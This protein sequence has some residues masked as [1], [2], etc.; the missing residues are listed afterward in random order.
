M[1]RYSRSSGKG[2]A[3]VLGI[4]F[5]LAIG[6]CSGLVAHSTKE[7]TGPVTVT[8][9]ERIRDGETDKYLIFTDAE[10]FENTDTIWFMKFTSSD[11]YREIKVGETYQFTVYGFRVG[12]LSSYRTQRAENMKSTSRFL[13]LR[14]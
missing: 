6:S 11:F 2:I 10:V 3:A 8:E 7:V 1:R 9:K 5:I 14:V 4:I 12:F 13:F